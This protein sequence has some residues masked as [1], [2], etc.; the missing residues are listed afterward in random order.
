[1]KLSPGF[2]TATLAVFYGQNGQQTRQVGATAHFWYLPWS[3]VI[4]LQ[5]ILAAIAYVLYR[6]V[7][8]RR[9]RR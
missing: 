5:V 2:Y 7:F 8:K 4:L 1:L 6:Y 9:P 3:T